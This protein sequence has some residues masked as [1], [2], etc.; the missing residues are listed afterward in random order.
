MVESIFSHE[1]PSTVISLGKEK[2]SANTR[3]GRRFKSQVIHFFCK[4]NFHNATCI[5][6]KENT[7]IS[8]NPEIIKYLEVFQTFGPSVVLSKICPEAGHLR[9]SEIENTAGEALGNS[10]CFSFH[11]GNS[12]QS[13][14]DGEKTPTKLQL[15]SA[16]T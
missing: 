8:K 4:N 2:A 5:S 14:A 13:W 10:P 15:T 11:L 9:R 16:M 7:D 12:L 1:S 6:K 3:K